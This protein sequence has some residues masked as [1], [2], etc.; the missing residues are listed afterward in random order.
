MRA[1]ASTL[2]PYAAAHSTA[3]SGSTHLS[4]RALRM[5]FV[6]PSRSE[7]KRLR[8]S[9]QRHVVDNTNYILNL[10]NIEV[11]GRAV[12]CSSEPASQ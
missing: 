7:V 2:P 5:P 1:A 12:L 3:V 4:A 8:S 9:I 10:Y 11:V 6:M